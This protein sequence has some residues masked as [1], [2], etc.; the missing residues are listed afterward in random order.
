MVSLPSIFSFHSPDDF[1][2]YYASDRSIELFGHDRIIACI[3]M[4]RSH[5][6]GAIRH[7]NADAFPIDDFSEQLFIV[8]SRDECLILALLD[9]EVPSLKALFA[10][11][12]KQP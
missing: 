4:T 7:Y 2:R 10:R 8:R 9:D 5:E 3:E 12:F 1:C 11:L 6:T